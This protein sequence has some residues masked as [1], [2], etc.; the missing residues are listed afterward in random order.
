MTMGVERGR[1]CGV[2]VRSLAD[3]DGGVTNDY[4]KMMGGRWLGKRER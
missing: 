3:R 1:R 2:I 4:G